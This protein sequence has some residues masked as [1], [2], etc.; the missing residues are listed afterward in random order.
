[1][2]AT[3]LLKRRITFESFLCGTPARDYV[4]QSDP[5]E[6]QRMQAAQAIADA[7]C[8][9]IGVGAGM[10][11]AAGAQYG[12]DFFEKNVHK[13]LQFAEVTLVITPLRNCVKL[14]HF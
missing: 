4:Y 13:A 5:Y 3:G 7:D 6:K 9:L 14:V 8:V 1:M 12:G 11:A 2:R 10:S